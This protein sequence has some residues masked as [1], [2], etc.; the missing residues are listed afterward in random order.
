MKIHTVISGI[1]SLYINRHL[2][3]SL[4]IREVKNSYRGTVLG[5]L[6]VVLYPL[7]MLTVYNFVFGDILNTRWEAKGQTSNGVAMLF[8]GLIIHAFFSE[9]LTQ[10]TS[11]V[12]SNPSYVKK[13]VF[14]LELLPV[15]KLVSAN[16]RMAIGLLSSFILILAK[17]K[18]IP[19]TSLLAPLVL[20]PLIVLTSGFAWFLAALGVFFRDV[21]QIVGLTMSVLLFLSPIFYPATAGPK[22]AQ[23]L[24]Y[25]NPLTYPI[26]ELRGVLILGE[27]IDWFHWVVYVIMASATALAGLWVFQKARP[28]FPDVI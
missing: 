2:L 5:F 9:T 7:M 15:T 20:L 27:Q 23:T 28:A 24:Y 4:V 19:T 21:G 18:A 26:E 14:P 6:W 11:V 8:C 22:L 17:D 16:F 1:H 13:I 25:L 10:C 12:L 3:R